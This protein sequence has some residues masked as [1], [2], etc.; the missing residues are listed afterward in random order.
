MGGVVQDVATEGREFQP[1]RGR[2]PSEPR[3]AFEQVIVPVFEGFVEREIGPTAIGPVRGQDHFRA[4][5]EEPRVAEGRVGDPARGVGQI[6][7]VE[8]HGARHRAGRVEHGAAG[9]AGLNEQVRVVDFGVVVARPSGETQAADQQQLQV[10]LDPPPFGI[11]RVHQAV[12]VDRAA[13]R[14]QLLIVQPVIVRRDVQAE[15]LSPCAQ[16][17]AGLDGNDVLGIGHGHLVAEEQAALNAGRPETARHAHV[18][19]HSG[20]RTIAEAHVPTRHQVARVPAD[21]PERPGADGRLETFGPVFLVVLGHANPGAELQ[22]LRQLE[23]RRGEHRPRLGPLLLARVAGQGVVVQ[24]VVVERVDLERLAEIEEPYAPV[25]AFRLRGFQADFLAELAQGR[26][27]V[28]GLGGE[29]N[30][31]AGTVGRAAAVHV[32]A[33]QIVEPLHARHRD[34]PVPS[35]VVAQVD[36]EAVPAEFLRI[37]GIQGDLV[38]PETRAQPTRP[39]LDRIGA[40]QARR[41]VEIAHVNLEPSGEVVHR[42]PQELDAARDVAVAAKGVVL[43]GVRVVHPVASP[44]HEQRGP[45]R[46]HGWNQRAGHRAL[47]IHA[48][49][50]AIGQAAIPFG[51][52]GGRGRFHLDEPGRGIAAEQGALRAAQHFD[53]LDVEDR[54][55][56]EQRILQRHAVVHHRHRLRSVQVEVRIPQAANEQIRKDASER[57]RDLQAGRTPGQKT[58][59][60]PRGAQMVEVFALQHGQGERHVDGPLLLLARGHDDFV[61][62]AERL[63]RDRHGRG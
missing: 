53:A 19:L 3:A 12:G 15:P 39:A 2:P 5:A 56:F 25:Q 43:A 40:E 55:A 49:E 63:G 14:G 4:V 52:P 26:V 57:R 62:F 22:V 21:R 32:A 36:G 9:A 60:A 31:V 30:R 11:V 27:A 41:P 51:C 24:R 6:V 29:G 34:E 38:A 46:E 44:L 7:A 50:P 28:R 61:Q 10:R 35:Q 20:R 54:G 45:G 1:A 47:E 59:V 33:R 23:G 16:L 18:G 8:R 17:D 42:R 13:A 58:D 48:V 37:L